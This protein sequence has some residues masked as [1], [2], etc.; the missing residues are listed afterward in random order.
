MVKYHCIIGF[1]HFSPR[2]FSNSLQINFII[3]TADPNFIG[4]NTLLF[5]CGISMKSFIQWRWWFI[6]LIMIII[7]IGLYFWKSDSQQ[8]NKQY[9]SI[10]VQRGDIEQTVLANG[11]L[12][13]AKLVSVGAR[14]SGQ[15]MKLYVKIGDEVRMGQ[16]IADIDSQPQHNALRNS[17]AALDSIKAN[18]TARQVSLKQ[19]EQELLRQ[20]TLVKADA[21]SIMEYEKALAQRDNLRAEIQAL[22][23][24]I[25]QAMAAVDTAKTDLGYTKITSPMDGKV[26]AIVTEEGRT[27]NSFQSAPTIVVLAKLDSMR[28]KAEISEADV[29]RVKAGQKLYFTILSEPEQRYYATLQQIEPAP[30]N[31]INQVDNNIT[32]NSANSTAAIYYNGLFD[33]DNPDGVLRPSM[34]VQ[35]YIILN[36]AKN[37]LVIPATALQKKPDQHIQMVK[38]LKADGSI[39]ERTILTGIS[40]GIQVQVMSGLKQGEQ[41]V[42]GDA[43]YAIAGGSSWGS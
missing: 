35:V 17:E 19:A 18:R 29:T 25:K 21:S 43:S 10:P 31:I 42:I 7:F 9:L 8:N 6:I 40:D 13:A 11:V 16:P 41:V 20:N 12:H 14:A 33:I 15:V 22:D 28:V 23:A 26:V 34:T 1:Y 37:I 32:S 4:C 36:E 5:A 2:I 30:T 3:L 24:Q 27:V 39:E 38:V